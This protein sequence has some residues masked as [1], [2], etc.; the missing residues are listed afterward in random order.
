MQK[1]W[2]YSWDVAT[3]RGVVLVNTI[4]RKRDC[5]QGVGRV[6]KNDK[7]KTILD[8]PY[9]AWCMCLCVCGWMYVSVCVSAIVKETKRQC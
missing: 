1:H 4:H 6:K 8:D 3:V 9:L 5:M 2:I 7:K